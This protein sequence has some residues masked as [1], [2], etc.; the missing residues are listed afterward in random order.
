[1][2]RVISLFRF[3]RSLQSHSASVI[4][5]F[6]ALATTL[7]NAQ[8]Y[9]ARQPSSVRYQQQSQGISRPQAASL[10]PAQ[11]VWV[12]GMQQGQ[13]PVGDIYFR[14]SIQL[15]KVPIAR[16]QIAADD[17]Y[18]VYINGRRVGTGAGV[19][20]LTTHE[21]AP[22][23]I[24]GDNIIAI[25]A[26]NRVGGTGA[27]FAR[28]YVQLTD[29]QWRGMGSSTTW[30]ASSRLEAGWQTNSF[31]DSRWQNAVL[32]GA[33]ASPARPGNPSV[34]VAGSDLLEKPE[35]IG[36]GISKSTSLAASSA[37]SS[38]QTATG[39]TDS[40]TSKNPTTT[41]T[42]VK[43]NL[44]KSGVDLS[45][46][47][48]APSGF[49]VEQ[50]VDEIDSGSVIAMAFN[51]F[52]HIIASQEGGPLLLIYETGKEKKTQRVRTYCDLVKNVQGILP[53]NGDL[54]VT[55]EGPEGNGLYRL[56]DADR[57]GRLE[58]AEK[59]FNV[60][61]INGE[62]GAHQIALGP[63]GMLYVVMGNHVQLDATIS[64]TSPYRFTYEGD[65][66]RPR[67]ED[68]SGHA[69][70]MKAPGGTVVRVDL[71]TK[72]IDIVAGGLRNAYDLAFHPSQGL[73]LQDSD[74]EAD[75]G[76]TWHRSTSLFKITEGGEYGWRS[77]WAAW[78]D[79]FVDRLPPTADTG[80]GSP[81]GAVFYD[82][83]QFPAEYHEQLFLADWSQGR[84]VR[85]DVTPKKDGSLREPKEFV[86]GTPMNVTDLD[87]GPDG[88]LY[89]STGGRGTGGGIY[90]VRWT[91]APMLAESEWG[92]GIARAI[93]QPQLNSAWGRQSI[94]MQKRELGGQWDELIAGVAFSPDNPSRYRLRALDLMQL[95]GPVPS[96]NLLIDLSRT[97]SE[98]LRVKVAEQLA[99][100]PEDPKVIERL[101]AMVRDSSVL[102]R[103]A[104]AESL[105][106]TDS[107]CD[108]SD[109]L[110]LLATDDR[111]SQFLARRL[112][113]RLPQDQ[114]LGATLD[115]DKP[116]VV[117]NG[118][119]AST[120]QSPTPENAARCL[121]RLHDLLRSYLSDESFVNL[122]RVY[123]VVLHL[124]P[125]TQPQLQR[126]RDFVNREFPAGQPII[127]R[128]LIRLAAYSNCTEISDRV[129]TYLTA[130][131]PLADRVHVAMY[132]C[133]YCTNWTAEQRTTLLEF[134]EDAQKTEGGSSYGLYIMQVCQGLGSQLTEA[135]AIAFLKKGADYPNAALSGLP[136][137]PQ[138][139]GV[140]EYE[141]LV[142]LDMQ[143]DKQG[144]ESDSY[145][146][147]KTG[148]TAI[149]ARSGDERSM[150]Y[151]RQVWRRSPDRRPSV[152][153]A[154]AQQPEGDNWDYIVRSLNI[155]EPYATAD[156]L[157]AL[158]SVPIAT[159]DAEALRQTILHALKLQESGASPLPAF[160]LLAYWA[161][162]DKAAEATTADEKIAAWQ[163]WYMLTYPNKP[164]PSLPKAE[165][166]KWSVDDIENYLQSEQGQFGVA[167][168]GKE[169]FVKAQCAACH[170]YG[171]V[172]TR[173]GPDLNSIA[174]RF[175]RRETLESI[176]YPS[177]V[178]SDQYS[179]SK[180]LTRDGSI[181]SGMS[182]TDES[183]NIR[184]TNASGETTTVTADEIEEVLVSKTSLMPS[185]LM[186]HLTQPEVRDLM[187]YLG[188]LAE[189]TAAD[190]VATLPGQTTRR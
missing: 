132:A 143:I 101:S 74:M 189:Q 164:D 188:L 21:C 183:G 38:R 12:A 94:A 169:V 41:L 83:Y 106:R 54:Y 43:K 32:A 82:H 76:T 100:H 96:T 13:V 88:S 114:W 182:S 179:S 162:D 102:V 10:P 25:R 87:I 108:A 2:N 134:F 109:L 73:Y 122:L 160:K 137:L 18:E 111:Q 113:L 9:D 170:R 147:L 68:P 7:A 124:S 89:F 142:G 60:K 159:D 69:A 185:G 6:V 130:D 58:A 158:A 135:E 84:I 19:N 155:L 136:K 117:I 46:R 168:N 107:T 187:C 115:S 176:L 146:R 20:N 65:L 81:T 95:V 24:G 16:I 77:G 79:Y 26:S 86:T 23:I 34:P 129:L 11:W 173:V 97:P 47:F 57:D 64:P 14:K 40:E 75:I 53:L 131:V 153:L 145:K 156:V 157:E 67:R 112:L 116:S 126:V 30:K 17:A 175:T 104:A 1:M 105:V 184:L 180:V 5:A 78:P 42:S 50:V 61:G 120:I 123:E 28:F 80:R 133:G 121:D 59:V 172:G 91:G 93:R 152:A 92:T 127:N 45:Q 99:L 128:E 15:P 149:L 63:D 166:S 148:L 110:S 48:S 138:T 141:E 163:E 151:L 103:R 33:S 181:H 118:I 171:D 66:V 165:E 55:G 35:A 125:T 27:V 62:H 190:Q 177:Q 154:L 150:R 4:F 140:A 119:L 37:S 98:P 90:R 39:N 3:R 31:D 51:E 85:V 70:G 139:L 49:V 52:G 186:N 8:K 72:A 44:T 178:I 22:L 167:S 29:G 71:R 56:I 36:S 161:G 174:S 144:F